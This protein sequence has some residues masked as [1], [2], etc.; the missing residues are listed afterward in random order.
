DLPL[1]LESLNHQ[2]MKDWS[3]FV[4]ENSCDRVEAERVQKMLE[5]SGLPHQF[6][7]SEKNIGFDGG[8][9]SLFMMHDA[10][11]VLLLNHDARLEPAY[12]EAVTHRI[13]SD[14]TIGSVTGLVYRWTNDQERVID[15]AGLEYRCLGRIVDRFAGERASTVTDAIARD[16]Q[17]FGVSGAIG[18]YR[19]SAVLRAGGLFD[20]TWFLYK[21]DADLAI[22]LKRAGF[23]AWFEPAA[24]A[25]H[26]R[27]LKEEGRGLF[28]R[29]ANERR[30]LPFLRQCSYENQW[31]MY[32]RYFRL[33]LGLRDICCTIVVEAGRSVLVFLASPRVFFRAWRRILFG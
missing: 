30:R 7:I 23:S 26:R 11:Y 33:S 25:F 27:G 5:A 24:V 28:D 3:L 32:R 31:R 21:E 2:T 10:A 16:G 6:F 4:C 17:V 9:Q 19:R 15:T 20:P 29:L 13:E 14:P 8:H 22:R 1:L 12:L 18:L